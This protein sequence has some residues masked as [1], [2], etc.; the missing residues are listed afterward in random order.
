MSVAYGLSGRGRQQ[1]AYGRTRPGPSPIGE[2]RRGHRGTVVFGQCGR[3]PSGVDPGGAAWGK[4]DG[5]RRQPRHAVRG[6][7]EQGTGRSADEGA[8]KWLTRRSKGRQRVIGGGL[9]RRSSI[10]ARPAAGATSLA[11]AGGG[12]GA[13]PGRVVGGRGGRGAVSTVAG[14]TRGEPER[15]QRC[16]RRARGPR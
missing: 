16:G 10:G 7:G 2:A 1:C 3:R 5:G 9:Q 4:R 6:H 11:G 8:T 13:R 15:G 14:A 12:R